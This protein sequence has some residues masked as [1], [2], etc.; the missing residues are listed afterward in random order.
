[1]RSLSIREIRAALPS[2]SELVEREGELIITRRGHPIARVVPVER[3]RSMPSNRELRSLTKPL[4]VPSE[5]VL[6]E[7]R[8]RS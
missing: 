1:M 8:D 6:R 5:V 4:E 7:E 3:T 2:L